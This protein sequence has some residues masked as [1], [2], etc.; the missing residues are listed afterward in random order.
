MKAHFV[1]FGDHADLLVLDERGWCMLQWSEAL[2]TRSLLDIPE[3][4]SGRIAPPFNPFPGSWQGPTE[5]PL[6][7]F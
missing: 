1:V 6:E 4:S 3:M 2:P 5:P 7:R